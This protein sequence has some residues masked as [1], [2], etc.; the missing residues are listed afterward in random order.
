M[1]ISSMGD[2]KN[3]AWESR[4]RCIAS[5]I[6]LLVV[7][8]TDVTPDLVTVTGLR[9]RFVFPE[10]LLCLPPTRPSDITT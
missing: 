4:S 7:V 5:L 2:T 6:F 10:S 8:W 3:T 1:G 9:M